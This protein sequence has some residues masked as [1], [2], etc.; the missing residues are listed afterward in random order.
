[1]PIST[2]RVYARKLST[3]WASVM[4]RFAAENTLAR[5]WQHDITLWPGSADEVS[6]IERNLRWLD[7]PQKL[8]AYISRVAGEAQTAR[9]QGLDQVVFV[10]MGGSNLAARAT[11]H[12]PQENAGPRTFLLDTTDPDAL[13]T[14][15]SQLSLERTVFVFASKS[16]KRI[17]THALLLYFRAKLRAAGIGM[18]GKHFVALTDEGSYL[19]ALAREYRFRNLF[20]D[21]H[22][23]S[24]RYS[25]LIHFGLL[26]AVFHEM[27][28]AA[29][30]ESIFSMQRTCGP[31]LSGPNNPALEL[32]A[33]LAAG[34]LHGLNR[35]VI[36][37]TS[38]EL[39]S[40]AYR[41]GQVVG[42]STSGKGQGQGLM[43]IFA[44][45]RDMASKYCGTS[46]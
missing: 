26:L 12:T 46:V 39:L 11:L 4:Q 16:G 18:T 33:F 31:S 34:S 8:G 17:E 6:H 45:V 35:L 3:G 14:L 32:A 21:P 1:M 25:G 24:S 23:I 19:A 36:L 10:G 13:H 15:E 44:Q 5:L 40:F 20:L 37:T 22:G 30:L 38:E 41:I 42:T 2:Q 7:L 43:P 9:A 29:L 27:D 28:V